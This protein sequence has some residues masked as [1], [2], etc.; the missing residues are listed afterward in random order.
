MIVRSG[1]P[2]DPNLNFSSHEEI[3]RFRSLLLNTVQSAFFCWK[4]LTPGEFV[5]RFTRLVQ[6][7]ERLEASLKLYVPIG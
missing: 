1:Y 7:D 2:S 3:A 5:E 4:Y 6:L